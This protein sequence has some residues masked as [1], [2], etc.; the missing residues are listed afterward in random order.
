MPRERC[1]R[2]IHVTPA[3]VKIDRVPYCRRCAREL[4][5]KPID[6]RIAPLATDRVRLEM[7]I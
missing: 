3:V 2:C 4:V 1:W 5:G 7:P 6:L